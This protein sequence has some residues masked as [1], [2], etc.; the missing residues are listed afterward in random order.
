MCG[1][2][3][4]ACLELIASA[5]QSGDRVLPAAELDGRTEGLR[6][7][8]HVLCELVD[9]VDARRLGHHA[10]RLTGISG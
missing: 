4:A 6:P 10:L 3:D 2:E 9:E 1:N 7:A 8:S 5:E